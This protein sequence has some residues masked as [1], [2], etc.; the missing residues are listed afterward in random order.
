MHRILLLI[1]GIIL[2]LDLL[3][4]SGELAISGMVT[5]ASGNPIP[6]VNIFVR[7]QAT[8]TIS[9]FDGNYKLALPA[10][11]ETLVFSYIGYITLEEPINNRS[12]INI[13]LQEDTKQ[14]EEIV[15]TGYGSQKKADIIGAIGSLNPA[16]IKDMPVVGLD[17]ALQGQIAGV[18]VTQSSGTP[19]GGIMVRVRG[20]SSI[21]SSNRPLYIVDGIPVR[22][23]GLSSRDFGGQNDNALSTLNPNDI[24]SIEVLKDASAKAI[25]GSRAANGVVIITTKRG[26]ADSPTTF[27]FDIQRGIIDPTNTIE[28]L[29][30]S[31]LLTLQREALTNAGED[32]NS[33]GTPG[34]TDAVNTNWQ[35]EVMRQ[36]VVQQY[37][38]STRGGS[39][40]TQFYLSAAYRDEEGV[41][42]NNRFQRGN[43]TTNIDHQA[44]DRLTFGL[45]LNLA[46]VKN[47]RIKGDNFLDGVYNASLTSLPFYQPY[48]EE[49]NLYAPGDAGYAGFPNFNPVGQ[50]L[51]PRF[52]TYATKMLGGLYARYEILP[53][54]TFTTRFSADYTTTIEDQYEPTTTAIGGFLQSVGQQGYGVYSTSESSVLLNNNVLNYTTSISDIHEISG[55]LGVEFISR[56]SRSGSTVGILFPSNDFTYLASSGL[57]IDGSSY[58]INSGLMSFFGEVNYKYKSKYL[59]QAT[60]RYDGSSRFGENRKYGLFPAGSAGWR[61][62]EEEFMKGISWLDDMKLRVSYGLTGNERIGDFRYLSTWA[63]V[64]AYNGV[65]AV[66]PATLGNPDLGWEQTSEFNI[67]TDIAL[68]EGK[69]QLTFDYYYN[70]TNDLLLNE[71]LPA[72]TGFGSVLGNLGEITNEG[73][74]LTINT[75]NID[76]VVKWTSQFNIAKNDNIVKKL[77]TDEPQFAGYSTF[78]NNTHIIT[79]GKPLGTFWGLEFLGVD[80]GTGDAIYK[81]MNND[82]QLT[83]N[84]GTFIGD[85]Q[86]DY[87]GGFTNTI[88]YKGFDVNIF[89]QYSMGN[90]MI[91]FGNT[92]LLNS[93]EDI[94]N[95]QSREALKRWKNEGDIA[96]I[97]R[98]EFG[99]TFNNRFSSRFVEDASYIRLKNLTVGY[100]FDQNII[101]K[102]KVRSLRIYASGTNVWT[103]TNYSG[104]DPEVNSLDGSTTAQGLDLYTFPQVRTILF[105]LNLGF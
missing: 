43:L 97:P 96:S 89:F 86:A 41:I 3:A 27:D 80:P 103:W 91:N 33:A 88:L 38:I 25:Y 75:V 5:D 49:G 93:G 46:R 73:I 52:D 31:E 2:S 32:P 9:G 44:T 7:G 19:G 4:Q 15:V 76:K 8:G 51:E 95:N 42:L 67:G 65:P 68:Y 57:I 74:E 100:T 37:Q 20:N 104:A 105:G 59:L 77:A 24:E 58:L 17:Q 98:Y 21:S 61:I 53:N 71:L 45:N 85:A 84:D 64:T 83:A 18:S 1:F 78:T 23:G 72:T 34:V 90:Q 69:I 14:L 30:A 63:A 39:D 60:V 82:G 35:D 54:L 12:V 66:A 26:K 47:K 79:P 87:F 11:V 22:D 102:L 28:V 13:T 56:I 10:G 16:V 101:S 70:I 50:A 40:K 99:N 92:S 6:G 29:N 81:D 55:L 48:D 36:A 94:S 62:S